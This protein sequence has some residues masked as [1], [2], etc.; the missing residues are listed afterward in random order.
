MPASH[1]TS[2]V[3]RGL[4]LSLCFVISLN[5][6]AL[7]ICAIGSTLVEQIQ[8]YLRQPGAVTDRP[9][10]V[11]LGTK[12][13]KDPIYRAGLWTPRTLAVLKAFRAEQAGY[14]NWLTSL[15]PALGGFFFQ[16]VGGGGGGQEGGG[17]GGGQGGG[18]GG[19]GGG[20]G[21][22][23]TGGG[24]GVGIG[25]SGAGEGA[26]TGTGRTSGGMGASVN[27]HTG[28][29]YTPMPIVGW[30]SVGQT[31]I[32]L[33]LSHSS[34][35]DDWNG[36]FGTAWTHSYEWK[37]DYAAS[38]AIVH[39]GDGSDV[40]FTETSGVF[41]A[42]PGVTDSLTHNGGGTWT[43]T[44][45][46]GKKYG[47]N[48]SGYLT[49]IQDR[50]GN[51]VTVT[52]NGSNKVTA[53]TD[54]GGKSLEFTYDGSG[55]V[56]TVTDPL[57][58]EWSFAYTSGNL[59]GITYPE[60]NSATP[61]RTL[62]YDSDHNIT[63]EQDLRGNTWT[64]NYDGTDRLTWWKNPLNQQTSYTYNSTNTVITLPGS[65]TITHNYSS[66]L[67]ASEVDP[68]SYSEAFTY[69]SSKRVLTRTDKRGKVWTY[70]YD[71]KGNVLTA[72][73]P[74]NHTTTITYNAT[75]SFP[76]TVTDPL[77]HAMTMTYDAQGNVL[78]ITDA[79]SRTFMTRTYDAYG[80]AVSTED[81]LSNETTVEYDAQG[82]IT[83]ITDPDLNET[84]YTYN[85]LNR[86]VTTTDPLTNVT[87]LTYDEWLR[88]IETEFPDTKTIS[89]TYDLEH[90]MVSRTDER[91]KTVNLT[92]DSA[93]RLTGFTNAVGDAE[94]YAYNSNGWLTTVTNG[95]SYTRTYTYNTRGDIAT[96]TMP[97]SSVESWSYNANGETSAFTN[98]LSQTIN[99]T[100]DDA[101]RI[102]AIDYPTGTDT[103]FTYDNADRR[104]QMVDA[105]G[106]TSWTY[107]NADELTAL[108]TPQGNLSYTYDNNGNRLTMVDGSLTTSYTYDV[109][110]RV[111]EVENGYGE[112]TTYQYDDLSRIT[113]RTLHSGQ[114]EAITYDSRSRTTAVAL[115]N[116]SNSTLQSQGY[117]FDD[118]GNVLTHTKDG[119]TTTYTY[120]DA[121]QILSESRS[122][123]S[124]SY[125]WDDNGN[126]STR[127]LNGT[128]ET[129]AYDS[130]DKL[131]SISVG[132]S[133]VKS[134][135]YDAAGRTTS[136]T[137]S[138]VATNIAYDYEDR[139][140]SISRS[141]VTTNT[142]GYNGLD[143][144][145]SKVDSTG[146]ATYKRDGADVLAPVLGDGAAVYT[147]G[148]SE[149]RSST[150]RYIHSGIKNVE[151]ESNTSQTISASR[152]YDAFGTITS[153]SGTWYGAFGYGGEFGYQE[154]GDYGVRLLGHRY[155]CPDIGRFLTRDPLRDGRNWYTYAENNPVRLAD[156][157][158]LSV[159]G[160]K[161]NK[162]AIGLVGDSPKDCGKFVRMCFPG[163][164]MPPGVVDTWDEWFKKRPNEWS[165][166]SNAIGTVLQPGDIIQIGKGNKANGH[167]IIVTTEGFMD[168]SLNKHKAAFRSNPWGNPLEAVIADDWKA[169]GGSVTIWRPKDPK[170]RPAGGGN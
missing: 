92:Y 134:F 9:T 133:T 106:T 50:N 124:C 149:R 70:T 126:R 44:T 72:K 157:S 136:I 23:T 71:S 123:Y 151:V 85:G 53:V 35:G 129:Y 118:A 11:F 115:K 56:A 21:G 96:L 110:G 39:T 31:G 10:K 38:T 100:I 93:M 141:G 163:R 51:T 28:N 3:S 65:Q 73:D 43:L 52:L 6:S 105:S 12:P 95:R 147:P 112:S 119:V 1:A 82:N 88:V 130:A 80:Q 4:A 128:T 98:P 167:V 67:L 5:S 15:E 99:Y 132:G 34:L 143:T 62:G 146:T 91:G 32:S 24:G 166:V 164:K 113:R 127:T 83:S 20:E 94:T 156:P 97:D 125:T 61:T 103:S 139:I 69:D 159:V 142:F 101:G 63:S 19:V 79:L 152:Q 145:V 117:T 7:G 42:P 49:S 84:V 160:E 2:A 33:V 107:N 140:T 75:Y 27:T 17:E 25:S 144:R 162:L 59:T 54:P 46:H 111:I 78:T 87:T 60:I 89:A 170:E 86:L 150:T 14:G 74:L 131:T 36:V 66:G 158:G 58:R 108:S 155:Y 153:S 41:S 68:S 76:L 47:F 13:G 168:A 116:S 169:R 57:D 64:M 104:T 77:S 26:S 109:L 120:D 137:Y 22:G 45:K 138:G 154:D 29:R 40:P 161:A 121:N 8:N 37:I 81:A 48:A 165:Q 30:D 114:Y 90:N 122:G 148:I 16:G 135:G 18:S 102:T 55:R